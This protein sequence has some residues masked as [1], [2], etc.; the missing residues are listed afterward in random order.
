V[1][2]QRCALE[3]GHA[4]PDPVPLNLTPDL[5][6]L[7]FNLGMTVGRRFWSARCRHF[8]QR[9]LSSRLHSR[10]DAAVLLPRSGS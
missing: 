4:R 3:H 8:G 9:A 6:V 2:G 5:A 1:E 7:G 10:M